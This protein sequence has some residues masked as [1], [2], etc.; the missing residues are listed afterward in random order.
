MC[1]YT[2]VC[3]KILI[4]LS[5]E[6]ES[7]EYNNTVDTSKQGQSYLQL[8]PEMWQYFDQQQQ[9]ESSAS[10]Q[11]QQYKLMGGQDVIP[12][13]IPSYPAS[14]MMPG[15]VSSGNVY[16]YPLG[17]ASNIY[18]LSSQPEMT[19]EVKYPMFHNVRK[20]GNYVGNVVGG[21]PPSIVVG[22]GGAAV[23]G[24][25]APIGVPVSDG[26]VAVGMS[27]GNGDGLGG[28]LNINLNRR[29]YQGLPPAEN[30]QH[31]NSHHHT[32]GNS[33]SSSSSG[34][35]L[36]APRENRIE[37]SN[38]MGS[39]GGGP[40][41]V[42][43]AAIE[44]RRKAGGELSP[45]ELW[46]NYYRNVG[47]DETRNN[48]NVVGLADDNLFDGR[49]SGGRGKYVGTMGSDPYEKRS[50]GGSRPINR[51][52][53]FID[54]END[55]TRQSVRSSRREQMFPETSYV[56]AVE[57]IQEGREPSPMRSSVNRFE[58]V[59]STSML[60]QER[61]LMQKEIEQQQR[62]R[63]EQQEIHRQHAIPVWNG[64]TS[65]SG[66][67][68]RSNFLDTNQRLL[69]TR[70]KRH[71]G[72]HDGGIQRLISTGKQVKVNFISFQAHNSKLK[73]LL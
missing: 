40:S 53:N 60:E 27:N 65:G 32:S 6:R 45:D 26:E 44:V 17:V 38:G 39:V 43:R 51:I 8:H 3:S 50:G 66:Y 13:T 18:D 73:K 7:S 41:V 63:Q 71:I 70:T 2:F 31:H 46:S 1:T 15:A 33:V 24:S 30:Q 48:D 29:Q 42:D 16:G 28:N 67:Y 9:Q 20:H 57:G 61:H 36:L 64:K 11:Q 22:G 54:N 49:G 59:D 23:D 69:P 55:D 21:A 19:E 35:V 5:E 68:E 10:S 12:E 58:D 47:A 56:N 72:P 37:A 34:T 62:Y 52:N 14:A 4:F 25:L